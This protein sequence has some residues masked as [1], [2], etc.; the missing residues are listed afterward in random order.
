MQVKVNVHVSYAWYFGHLRGWITQGSVSR[1]GDFFSLS[2]A[3]LWPLLSGKLSVCHLPSVAESPGSDLVPAQWGPSQDGEGTLD[4]QKSAIV[5]DLGSPWW[6]LRKGGLSGALG[7]VR[8]HF[9]NVG[10]TN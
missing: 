7:E 2:R 10:E 4:I 5:V 6:G 3:N 9:T 8:G 1:G